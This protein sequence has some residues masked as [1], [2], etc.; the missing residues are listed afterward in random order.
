[1]SMSKIVQPKVDIV[2][3][4]K[5]LYR[6]TVS[7]CNVSVINAIR[8]T[9]LTDIDTVVIDPNN[10]NIIKNTTQFNNEILKQR[11]ACIPVHIKDLSKSIDNLSLEIHVHNDEDHIK[12]V[13]TEDFMLKDSIQNTLLKKENRDIVFP[14][15]PITGDYILFS[16][17]KP[18]ITNEIGGEILHIQATFKIATAG[19]NGSYNV[20]S[21]CGYGNTIDEGKIADEKQKFETSLEE[22]GV[23]DDILSDKLL[24]WE[25]HTSK[26][27]FKENSFDFVLESIGIWS[28][29]EIIGMACKSIISRLEKI[30]KLSK[31]GDISIE[32]SPTAMKNSFDI[33]LENETY[34]IGKLIEYVLHY[35]YLLNK[36]T[37]SY[38]GFLKPHPHDNHSIIRIAYTSDDNTIDFIQDLLVSSTTIAE[39]I[40]ETIRKQFSD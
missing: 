8:R 26:R 23:T 13:T 40:I 20:V 4:Q 37:L 2:G 31:D 14:K 27:Y 25:N 24:N 34:T 33:R 11:L 35:E 36:K 15:N 30:K 29:R 28:N 38:V 22:K 12:N 19:E 18:K 16:R 7:N 39:N 10:I 6:F 21:T 1:M 32:T 9:I 17:L 3:K 5:N